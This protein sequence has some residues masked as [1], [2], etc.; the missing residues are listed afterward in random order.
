[1]SCGRYQL[2]LVSHQILKDLMYASLRFRN[3]NVANQ[4]QMKT[5]KK[6]VRM[7]PG[8]TSGPRIANMV[9]A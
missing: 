6:I 4:F 1:M 5:K 7:S 8:A 9:K 2:T 3:T